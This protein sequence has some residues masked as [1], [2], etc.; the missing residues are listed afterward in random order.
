MEE[1][2]RNYFI[3]KSKEEGIRILPE[4]FPALKTK[5][6]VDKW[7]FIVKES[8]EDFFKEE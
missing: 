2:V 8:F 4:H 1:E 7:I 6:D 3:Q 5:E